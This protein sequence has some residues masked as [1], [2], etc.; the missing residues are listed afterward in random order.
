M[1]WQ[2]SSRLIVAF[3][4][5]EE[6]P[7]HF[8]SSRGLS[9]LENNASSRLPQSYVLYSAIFTE[10][11][12]C[13]WYFIAEW[14][15]IESGGAREI[16]TYLCKSKT[17]DDVPATLLVTKSPYSLRYSLS[18]HSVLILGCLNISTSFSPSW[19]TGF[20]RSHGRKKTD[21]NQKLQNPIPHYRQHDPTADYFLNRQW[22]LAIPAYFLYLQDGQPYDRLTTEVCW[23]ALSNK[24]D[25]VT[26]L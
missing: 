10:L 7:D 14:R 17:K 2:E 26:A 13:T 18:W 21:T 22:L 15:Q 1:F 24:Y 25:S 9:L 16:S 11:Y 5:W 12:T 19:P 6:T 23:W 8:S 20:Q 4:L 3:A